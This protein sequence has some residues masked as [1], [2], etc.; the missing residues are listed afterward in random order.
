M[1]NMPLSC[2]HCYINNCSGFLLPYLMTVA[3]FDMTLCRHKLLESILNQNTTSDAPASNS[4]SLKRE[5]KS[6]VGTIGL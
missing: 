2:L 5:T 3:I 6:V 4:G 1:I